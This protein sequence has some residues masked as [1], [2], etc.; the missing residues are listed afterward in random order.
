MKIVGSCQ[1]FNQGVIQWLHWSGPLE[2][3]LAWSG[4]WTSTS[5]TPLLYAIQPLHDIRYHK[6]LWFAMVLLTIQDF[7]CV[8][9]FRGLL[10]FFPNC[11]SSW[12]WLNTWSLHSTS[13]SCKEMVPSFFVSSAETSKTLKKKSLTLLLE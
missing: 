1:C 9:T 7:S 3:K 10:L 11:L 6:I 2:I 5:L 12:S 4:P 8:T 13:L